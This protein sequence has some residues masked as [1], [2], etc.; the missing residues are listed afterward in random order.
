MVES[1]QHI[2]FK[3]ILFNNLEDKLIK[4]KILYNQFLLWKHNNYTNCSCCNKLIKKQ[5]F[6]QICNKF[7]FCLK[8]WDNYTYY[9]FYCNKHHCFICNV[10]MRSCYKCYK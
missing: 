7:Y 10:R 4:F 8:C 1:L 6:C 5:S 9:C 3:Y 2:V